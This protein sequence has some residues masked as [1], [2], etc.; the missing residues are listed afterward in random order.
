MRIIAGRFRGRTLKA[1]KGFQI[2]PSTDRVRE[3]LFNLVSSRMELEDVR[4]LD[5]YAGSGSLGLEALSRGAK[6]AVFVES[7][8]RV[9]QIARENAV[10]LGVVSECQFIR[11]DVLQF[12]K[13][14][15]GQPFDFLQ[16]AEA[17]QV[18][19]LINGEHPQTMALVLAHLRPE[20]ASAIMAGLPPADRADVAMRIPTMEQ[21][22]PDAVAI[23]AEALHQRAGSV[24]TSEESTT[25]IGGVQPLVEILNRA[26][27]GTEKAILDGLVQH[28]ESLAEQVRSLMFTFDDIVHL[29]DRAVQLVMRHTEIPSLAIALKGSNSEVMN[30][31]TSNLSERVRENLLEEIEIAGPVRRSEIHDARGAIVKTIRSLEESGQIIVRRDAEDEL[32]S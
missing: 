7:D 27:P 32:V 22:N 12:F 28:D 8:A 24:L 29:D 15:A 13:R 20:R 2:R 6:H 5:L 3:S 23:V 18:L 17:R 26:D 16:Q 11:S 30:K 10:S 14:L 1:P 9:L 31:I 4:V 21:A 19:S 25:V